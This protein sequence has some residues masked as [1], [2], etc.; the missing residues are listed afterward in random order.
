VTVPLAFAVMGLGLTTW[1][2]FA[3]A[4]VLTAAGGAS[5]DGQRSLLA[6][7]PADLHERTPVFVGNEGLIEDLESAVA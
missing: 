3:I 2:C 5:S 4:Y 7:T 6:K 1:N